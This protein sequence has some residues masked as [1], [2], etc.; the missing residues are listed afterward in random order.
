MAHE[1]E[2]TDVGLKAAERWH[3][4]APEDE[5]AL[6]FAGVFE[7]RANR[8]PAAIARF[9]AFM[10]AADDRATGFALVL[11][12]L[13]DEPYARA[14]TAI[15]SS[16]NTTFPNVPAGQYGLARLALRSGDFDVALTNAEAASKSDANWLEAQLLYARALLVDRKS[17]RLNS[18]H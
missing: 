18:S 8:L 12:A 14:A 9:E 1:L 13:A 5:R 3:A 11:E 6:W 7:M 17:T 16:L 4:L 2:L 10:R 15:M